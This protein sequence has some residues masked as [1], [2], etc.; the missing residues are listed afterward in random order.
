MAQ[1]VNKKIF[2]APRLPQA[3]A[4]Q[5]RGGRTRQYL[6]H[7]C[8]QSA[9]THVTALCFRECR[10]LRCVYGFSDPL[11]PPRPLLLCRGQGG[12]LRG[13]GDKQV[14][15]WF[16]LYL[17]RWIGSKFGHQVVP[18]SLFAKLATR[19]RDLHCHITLDCPIGIISQSHIS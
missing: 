7:A 15:G 4:R 9:M 17:L 11:T 5:E 8:H 19:L 14:K 10:P 1:E 13:S 6:C 18:F 16:L 2:F 3:F 12:D